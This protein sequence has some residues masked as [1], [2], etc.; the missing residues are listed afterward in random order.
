MATNYDELRRSFDNI[1]KELDDIC[2]SIDD[3]TDF[4]QNYYMKNGTKHAAPSIKP[5]IAPSSPRNNRIYERYKKQI[6]LDQN[7]ESTKQLRDFSPPKIKISPS[8][9]KRKQHRLPDD[10]K[11]TP[12]LN[13]VIGSAASFFLSSDLKQQSLTTNETPPHHHQLPMTTKLH[14]YVNFQVL[15]RINEAI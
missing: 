7:L 5:P 9:T 8:S 4:E 14:D 3:L 1:L 6:S 13:S 10:K 2:K 11:S 12:L 15:I